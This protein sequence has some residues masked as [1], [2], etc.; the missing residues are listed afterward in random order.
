MV[1]V[2]KLNVGD[3]LRELGRAAVL[4]IHRI[5]PPGSF[6]RAE[7]HGPHVHAHIRP[8]AYG[9]AFDAETAD[10]FTRVP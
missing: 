10:Q 8:G 9:T 4:T 7:R 3:R 5:D 6:G 1:D 2:W